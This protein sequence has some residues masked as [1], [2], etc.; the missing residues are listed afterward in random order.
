V[1][2]NAKLNVQVAPSN[3]ATFLYNHNDKQ[4]DG[5]GASVVATTC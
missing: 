2:W 1:N 3:S 4:V 5:R